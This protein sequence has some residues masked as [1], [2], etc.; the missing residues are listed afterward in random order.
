TADSWIEEHAKKVGRPYLE[1]Y[2]ESFDA[3]LRRYAESLENTENVMVE[4][5]RPVEFARAESLFALLECLTSKL[6]RVGEQDKLLNE[7]RFESLLNQFASFAGLTTTTA[8]QELRKKEGILLTTLVRGW[9]PD[10]GELIRV[11]QP[12][13]PSLRR[14]MDSQAAKELYRQLCAEAVPKFTNQV[15]ERFREEDYTNRVIA[16][17][18]E[19]YGAINI[20]LDVNGPLWK[21]DR[22]QALAFFR[23]ESRNS[24]VRDNIFELLHWI[25]LIL[26][27][28][29]RFN[30]LAA[31]K[32]LLKDEE[33]V[34][35]LWSA[36]TSTPL[37]RRPVAWLKDLP[38]RLEDLGTT[39]TLP[40]WWNRTLETLGLS[41]EVAPEDA[42]PSSGTPPEEQAP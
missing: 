29:N 34:N 25:D 20:L 42:D 15:L 12:F 36:L 40:D 24:M 31:V 11:L 18:P 3:T 35:V 4:S 30:D 9:G 10:I 16:K 39:V 19:C 5:E 2:R 28:E 37:G 17:R 13:Q 6:G 32:S 22:G 8:Y 1:V 26:K 27:D 41:G 21:D 38:K 33:I 7:E 14:G 23:T